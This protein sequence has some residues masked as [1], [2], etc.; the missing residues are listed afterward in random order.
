MSRADQTLSQFSDSLRE[1]AA[2]ISPS[3]VQ[4]VATGYGI[5]TDDQDGG[6]SV[7]TRERST[8][9]GVILSV[10]GYIM[11]NAHVIEGARSIRVKLNGQPGAQS[12][13][14]EAKL[15]GRDRLVDL[16]LLKV[17]A[18]A[19]QPLPFGN[20]LNV[21]QGQL[22]LAAGSPL[23]MENSVSMGVVSAASRQFSEDDPRVFIQTDTPINPGNSGGPLVDVGGRMVGINTMILS[24]SGG[25]EG[26]G[27]AIP[28]NVV[29]SVYNSLRQDG[30]VRRAEIGIA[31]R[32]ITLPF[33]LALK[34]EPEKGIL[35]EDVKPGGAADEAGVRVGDVILTIDGT[36]LHNVRDLALQL[37]EYKIGAPVEFLISRGGSQLTRTI[38]V[39]ENESVPGRFADMINPDHD[40]ISRLQIL[41]VTVNDNIRRIVP[42]REPDGV[43]VAALTAPPPYFG[44]QI[45][46]GDV[47]HAVNG[48]RVTTVE[49]LRSELDGI[50]RGQPI[51]LEAER[52]GVFSFLALETD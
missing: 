3:V 40:L 35:V 37:Y 27:F 47:I 11:T 41:A 38:S 32:T 33:A 17:S 10:D 45:R 24:R 31:A 30:R 19:L 25:S 5:R 15:I 42:L 48:H 50:Q 4:V 34:L 2:S 22:V 13:L 28:S 7:I 9:S 39:R 6:A 20:S 21:T 52:D 51:V 36:P 14:L 1:L 26:V 44:D 12:S 16:A 8:G 18:M 29:R 43:I 23:G 46:E 49:M